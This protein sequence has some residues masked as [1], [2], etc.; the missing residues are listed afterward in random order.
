MDYM[1]G[2]GN[3]IRKG[4]MKQLYYNSEDKRNNK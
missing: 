2:L 1:E 4:E 3:S